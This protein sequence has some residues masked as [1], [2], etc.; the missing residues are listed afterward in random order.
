MRN[1]L[2]SASAVAVLAL[3]GSTLSV[4]APAEAS[5]L[6]TNCT[7]LNQRYHHGV[8]RRGAHDHT[9]GTPVTSFKRSTR[10]YQRAMNHNSDLDR[11][12]DGIAC[13]KL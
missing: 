5:V 4:A 3:A 1:M 6:F 13:E 2:T 12:R 7:H 10:L 9:S 11:D 8:G